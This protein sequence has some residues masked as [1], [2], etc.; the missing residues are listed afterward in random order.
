MVK[1]CKDGSLLGQNRS[2]LKSSYRMKLSEQ[3]KGSKNPS[4]KDGQSRKYYKNNTAW[5]EYYKLHL[6]CEVCNSVDKLITHHKD[7]DYKNNQV[8][9]LMV[10]CRSC[11]NKIHKSKRLNL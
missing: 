5:A 6:N 2:Y 11:H 9:N 4:W 7:G 3:K 1:I 10:V 8:E